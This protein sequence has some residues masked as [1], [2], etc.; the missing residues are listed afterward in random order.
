MNINDQKLDTCILCREAGKHGERYYVR[1]DVKSSIA[2]LLQKI[3][4]HLS[5][6]FEYLPTRTT[7]LTGRLPCVSLPFCCRT[8]KKL[9]EKRQ[10]IVE[11]LAIVDSDIIKRGR[12]KS[13]SCVKSID[14]SKTICN[15]T[16]GESNCSTNDHEI[17]CEPIES[18][19]IVMPPAKRLQCS[20]SPIAVQCNTSTLSTHFE[21]FQTHS[22]S[23][24]LKN[25]GAPKHGE[26]TSNMAQMKVIVL[27]I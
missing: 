5:H 19:P 8:C 3:P 27:H 16:E 2:D 15:N 21:A 17:D 13:K 14:F 4:G 1:T 7:D 6:L 22:I 12:F 25:S 24:V 9:I 11:N 10:R 18:S 26:P 23:H 20:L